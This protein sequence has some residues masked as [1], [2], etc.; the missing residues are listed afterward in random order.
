MLCGVYLWGVPGRDGTHDRF[1]QEERIDGEED[2]ELQL[3]VR[4]QEPGIVGV[5]VVGLAAAVTVKA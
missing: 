1:K 4:L 3:G 2:A 5:A